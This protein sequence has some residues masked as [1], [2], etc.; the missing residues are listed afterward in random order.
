MDEHAARDAVLAR[1]IE[2]T[3]ERRET[4]SDADRMWASRTAAARVAKA[5]P[6]TPSSVRARRS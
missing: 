2:T 3:D 4:W 1:A 5:R 6:T